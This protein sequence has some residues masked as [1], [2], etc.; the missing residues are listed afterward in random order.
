MS[1]ARIN[2]V[3]CSLWII[4]FVFSSFFSYDDPSSIFFNA[5]RAY[6]QRFSSVRAAEA[7]AYIRNPPARVIPNKPVDKLLCIGIPSV[8]RT[9]ESFLSSTIATLSDTLTPEE[10]ASIRIVVLLADKSPSEHFAYG[11]PWLEPLVDEVL[12]YGEPPMGSSVYRRIP[13]DLKEGNTRGDGRVENMRLDH[14]ALVEACREQEYPYF[15]LV[16]DDIVTTRDWFPRFKKGL[17]YVERKT[18][19]TKKEWIYLRLFYSEILMGWNN[20]EWLS[21]S[22]V[23]CLVYTAVLVM[24]LVGRKYVR[25]GVSSSVSPH[26][27]RYLAALLFGLW[28]P[29]LI[30]LYFLS[31]RLSVNRL[32]PFRLSALHGA[33]EM[34]H[35]GCCAQG[36]V[37]PQRHLADFQ[38][39][40]RDPPY[41]F[42]GDMILEDYAEARGWVKWALEPSVFQHVGFKESS[43]GTRRAEVWN[44]GFERLYR[45]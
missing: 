1:V 8:N 38:V 29:A 30:A 33:R 22:K 13:F 39:L 34:P 28:L 14:S 11:Q 4:L 31:G 20:E 36:L 17:A 27:Q 12:L 40:L 41:D 25:V 42:P 45:I 19:E 7:D 23:I 6:K 32:N 26:A 37:L 35:Y 2:A 15:A 18:E 16:E 43:D 24:F 9:T 5:E 3:F 10:R 21:Y 44:F